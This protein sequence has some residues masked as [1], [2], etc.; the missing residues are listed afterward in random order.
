MNDNSVVRPELVMGTA[1]FG[2]AYGISNRSGKA[3]RAEIIE[4]LALARE[5]GVRRI[6]TA[7]AYGDAESVLGEVG[8]SDF[9]IVTKLP[10]LPDGLDDPKS[11]IAGQLK[12]SLERLQVASLQ[13]ILLHDTKVLQGP[14]AGAVICAL[15]SM[16]DTGQVKQIGISV[17]E[18]DE[19]ARVLPLMHF[20]LVQAPLN[21]LDTRFQDTGWLETL[22]NAGIKFQARSIF[23]QGLLLM[24]SHERP[25]KFRRW[26]HLWQIWDDWLAARKLLAVEA[27]VSYA[28]SQRLVDS[29]VVGFE[30]KAQ[31][32]ALLSSMTTA[33]NEAPDWPSDIPA[34]LLNPSRWSSL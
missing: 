4:M 29:C 27:C 28:F 16:R 20:D 21:I 23:L 25:D 10:S 6:D 15:Q 7:I 2:L 14:N 30:N 33:Q 17:Y 1:Q 34:T 19:L 12:A 24:A 26:D 5:S 13:G 9:D 8:V 32:G 11:F 3:K 31:L 18:P 22:A